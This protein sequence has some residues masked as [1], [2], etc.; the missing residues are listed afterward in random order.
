M[1]KY[2]MVLDVSPSSVRPPVVRPMV[3]SRKLSKIDPYLLRNTI[4]KLA[5]L[6]LLSY[7]DPPQT[8]PGQI[9]WFQVQ[10]MCK[11]YYDLLFDLSSETT[12]VSTEQTVV[13][14]QVLS[15]VV[16]R[17]RRCALLLTI[18][19]RCV[20]DGKVEHEARQLLSQCDI[21]VL[22]L[23]PFATDIRF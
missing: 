22:T 5:S 16:N 2:A 3:I 4:G 6:I 23:C 14:P 13:T 18:T 10:N 19:V 11:Y 8:P 7:L 17:A 1:T 20:D 9:F 12:A 15:A 21:L